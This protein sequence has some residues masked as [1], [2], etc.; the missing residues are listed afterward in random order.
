MTASK[1]GGGAGKGAGKGAGTKNT[2]GRGQ[3][4]LKTRVKTAKGRKISSTLWLERQLNDPYVQAARRDGYR[5][6]AAYKLLQID[7][8]YRLLKPGMRVV[9][10][11][12]APGGWMQVA[13]PRVNAL[14]EGRGPQGSVLGVDLQE[15]EQLAGAAAIQL[16]FLDE[17][18]DEVVKK[19]LGG[20]A[21]IVLSDMAAA[22]SG[23]RATDHLRIIA[24]CEAAAWFARDVLTP[25]GSFAAK[26]L[27]GGAEGELLAMLKKDFAKVMHFKPDASRK[28]SAE[29]YLVATG[30]RGGRDEDAAEEDGED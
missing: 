2:S 19:A 21:D 10:L 28:D 4:D 25:G 17:G 8:K 7:D 30:F 23:H 16:D 9:D 5:G 1:S 18:A 13:V 20:P 29:M 27:Q 14:G 26:V 12:C 11:G 15:V 22:S 6:R 24:L 3:R